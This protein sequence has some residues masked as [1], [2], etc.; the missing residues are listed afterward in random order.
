MRAGGRVV[1]KD[2]MPITAGEDVMLVAYP[3]EVVEQREAE[4]T[5]K[6]QQL[7]HH[8]RYQ[9]WPGQFDP[10]NEQQVREMRD[11]MLQQWKQLQESGWVSPTRGLPLTAVDE[12]MIPQESILLMEARA[13]RGGRRPTPEEAEHERKLAQ[14]LEEYEERASKRGTRFYSIPK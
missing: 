10:T 11:Q 3:K 6:Q 4:D 13:R 2:G 12:G 7:E 5:Q 14:K 9:D 1:L 8:L